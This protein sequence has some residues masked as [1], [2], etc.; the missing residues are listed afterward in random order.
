[1]TQKFEL[2]SLT[3]PTDEQL[4]MIMKD[5][6]VDVLES[7]KIAAINLQKMKD[8]AQKNARAYMIALDKIYGAAKA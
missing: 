8:E 1:M 3:E 2:T 7:N 4:E 6:L 5:A